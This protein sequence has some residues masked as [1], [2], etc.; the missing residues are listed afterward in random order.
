MKYIVFDLGRVLVTIRPE[1]V[2]KK[3]ADLAGLSTEEV[4]PFLH[5]EAHLELMSGKID[6]AEFHR[7]FNE[8]YF[9]SINFQ[10]FSKIWEDMIGEANTG[11]EK[12]L[13]SLEPDYELIIC[14]NTDELHWKKSLQTCDFIEKRFS[15]FFLSYKLGLIK[16]DRKIFQH[17]I[18]EL[19]TTSEKIVFID[20]TLENVQA[21]RSCGIRSIH[22]DKVENMREALEQ[23]FVLDFKE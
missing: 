7:K 16:P 5:G 6:F 19:E 3:L 1:K 21:A 17:I 22:A 23:E 12:L 14:S 10:N 20:D 4:T 13:D 8:S 15:R 2:S 11:I 18:T 9:S